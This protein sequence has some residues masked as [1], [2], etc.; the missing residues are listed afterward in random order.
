MGHHPPRGISPERGFPDGPAVQA[1]RIRREAVEDLSATLGSLFQLEVTQLEGG[2]F[3]CEIEFLAAG[4]SLIYREAYPRKTHIEGA[5]LGDRFG[6]ALPLPKSSGLFRGNAIGT[7]ETPTAVGGEAFHYVM[8]RD[9]RH[10][11]VLLDRDRLRTAAVQAGL[12]DSALRFFRHGTQ[13][14]VL[15]PAAAPLAALRQNLSLLLDRAGENAPLPSVDAVE[16]LAIDGVL[17]CLDQSNPGPTRSAAAALIRRAVEV[18]DASPNIPRIYELSAALRVSPRTLQFA[19]RAHTGIGPHAFFE[20]RRLNRARRRLLAEDPLQTGVTSVA[21]N[22]GFTE[23]GRF[24]G[25]YR[26]LFG[27]TPAMS[28]RRTARNPEPLPPVGHCPSG[29]G[30]RGNGPDSAAFSQL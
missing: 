26:R 20:L 17:L 16:G 11:V 3:R 6:L 13:H 8:E 27:E 2:P 4:H 12:A 10:I 21:V 25:R 30:K 18:V 15:R 9:F 5:L 7:G 14:E 29:C 24:A 19:F 28:L 1:G 23:L 22:L